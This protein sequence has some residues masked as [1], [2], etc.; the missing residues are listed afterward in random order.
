MRDG[1]Q[2]LFVNSDDVVDVT[3]RVCKPSATARAL[4]SLHALMIFQDLPED[5]V[6]NRI[7]HACASWSVEPLWE[8]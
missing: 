3:V 2:N 5:G 6:Q 4:V 1:T 8:P 7:T